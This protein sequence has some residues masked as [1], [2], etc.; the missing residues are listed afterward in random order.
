MVNRRILLGKGPEGSRVIDTK[1]GAP[2]ADMN[3]EYKEA[4]AR[5]AAREIAE[6]F[7]SRMVISV[8]DAAE[9]TEA[10]AI[11]IFK[12]IILQHLNA[13]CTGLLKKA[14]MPANIE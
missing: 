2:Q 3:F 4:L 14:L 8:G 10:S 1:R 13:S 5:A 11:Q 12:T 9:E 6:R 7:I